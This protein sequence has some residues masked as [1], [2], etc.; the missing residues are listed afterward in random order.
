MKQIVGFLRDHSG[1]MQGVAEVARTDYNKLIGDMKMAAVRYGIETTVSVVACGVLDGSTSPVSW[2]RT[3]RQTINKLEVDRE[4]ISAVDSLKV[5]IANGE[6]TPLYDGIHMLIDSMAKSKDVTDVDTSCLVMVTTDGA[7]NSSV[8]NAR[9]VVERINRLNQNGN[10]TLVL[11]VPRG[12]KVSLVRAGFDAENVLEFNAGD[13]REYE[14]ATVA[15]QAAVSNYY[16]GRTR[17][18]TKSASFFADT[19]KI[20]EKAVKSELANISKKVTVKRIPAAWEKRQIQDFVEQYMGLTYKLGT[21]YYQL[22]KS[23]KIQDSKAIIVWDKETG[24]YYT[25]PEARSLIG[26]PDTGTVT[27]KPGDMPRYEIFVQS[28]SV[29]RHLVAGTKLVIYN[30]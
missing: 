22:S 24:Y 9:S 6:S 2:Y 28:M 10:W 8:Q 21:A 19:S 15:T 12:A 29:N 16:E 14:A 4:G 23:E 5:Y 25:G 13:V 1:S 11:R 18:I 7:D 20:K 30:G 3:S 26:L 17:G 27:V